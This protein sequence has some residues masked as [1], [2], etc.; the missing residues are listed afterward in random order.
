MV[1]A[2][3]NLVDLDVSSGGVGGLFHLEGAGVKKFSISLK[4]Q[5]K[6]EALWRRSQEKCR[7]I[8]EFQAEGAQSLKKKQ[9]G[10]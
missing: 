2:P 10:P 4:T 1:P 7:D 6:Q 5:K 3:P 8:P 9:V